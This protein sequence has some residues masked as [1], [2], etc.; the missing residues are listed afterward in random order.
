MRGNATIDNVALSTFASIQL[1][2]NCADGSVFVI[3]DLSITATGV[4]GQTPPSV[5]RM[6]NLYGILGTSFNVPQP[7]ISG[8]ATLM[9]QIY[10]VNN[11][12]NPFGE[13]VTFALTAGAY[14][15]PHDWPCAVLRPGWSC[16]VNSDFNALSVYAVSF[17]WEQVRH[18]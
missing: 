14:N 15:W 1:Y 7:L 11:Y 12:S 3:W 8:G 16:T 10:Y 6:T 2:N 13:A 18:L 4:T 5:A 17:M 9:G